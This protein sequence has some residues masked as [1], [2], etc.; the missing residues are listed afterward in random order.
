M[1]TRSLLVGPLHSLNALAGRP[2]IVLLL[3]DDWSFSD[4]RRLR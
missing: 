3:A 2:N 4:V 1:L